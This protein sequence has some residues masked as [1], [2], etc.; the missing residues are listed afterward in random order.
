MRTNSAFIFYLR[1]PLRFPPVSDSLDLAFVFLVP[2]L[3]KIEY[4]EEYNPPDC[5][6]IYYK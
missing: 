1:Y 5:I 6:P 2:L 4:F 3:W